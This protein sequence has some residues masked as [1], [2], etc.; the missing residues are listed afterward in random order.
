MEHLLAGNNRV[1]GK[2]PRWAELRRD[3]RRSYSF[4]I[5]RFG[6]FACIN[7]A[8]ARTYSGVLTAHVALT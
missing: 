3:T 2:L 4:S 5:Y 8:T 6:D 1:E 7:A